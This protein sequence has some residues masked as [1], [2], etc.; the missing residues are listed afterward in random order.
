MNQPQYPPPGYAPPAYT[1]AYGAPTP[2]PR[3]SGGLVAGLVVASVLALALLAST[4]T[5]G[6]LWA[7]ANG[8]ADDARTELAATRQAAADDARAEDIAATYA[9]GASSFDYRDLGPWRTA[10]VKGVSP[11]LKT[12]L[13]S[14]AGAMNQLLQPLRWVSTGTVLDAVV[15]SRSGPVS[16]VNTYVKVI[17]TNSQSAGTREVLTLYTVTVDKSRDWLITDVGGVNPGK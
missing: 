17:S 15:T 1:P 13:E 2:P 11:E 7:G 16:K 8:R 9:A 5:F 4:V 10:L 3:R 6:V 12:K 14:T